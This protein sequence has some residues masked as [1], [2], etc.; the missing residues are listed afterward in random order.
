MTALSCDAVEM[1]KPWPGRH[2]APTTHPLCAEK[3]LRDSASPALRGARASHTRTARSELPN[4]TS[5]PAHVF[6]CARVFGGSV[7]R[8]GVYVQMKCLSLCSCV[9][10]GKGGVEGGGGEVS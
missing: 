6:A 5:E 10:E 9:G 3:A 8:G 2:A 7:W 4:A 1:W